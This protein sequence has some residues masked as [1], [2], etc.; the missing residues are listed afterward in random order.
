M[1]VLAWIVLGLLAGAIAKAIMPGASPGGVIATMLVG[2]VGAFIDGWVGG[3][4]TGEGL[5]GFTLWSLSLAVVGAL[6]FLWLYRISTRG[7][8][9]TV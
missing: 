8:T 1:T 5:N 2:I 7:R 4:L 9:P 6:L 3:V